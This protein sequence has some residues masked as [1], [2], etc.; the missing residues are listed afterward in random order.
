MRQRANNHN[1]PGFIYALAEKGEWGKYKIGHTVDPHR[2]L[3]GLQTGN[4]RELVLM[5]TWRT[6]NM[7]RDEKR[8]HRTLEAY[9][10]RGEWFECK[11]AVVDAAWKWATN[12][13]GPVPPGVGQVLSSI[14]DDY[15][16]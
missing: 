13:T 10:M 2:R 3:K 14:S 15:K 7:A 12:T 8:M 1:K 6:P 11:I 5:R 9:N 4:R 16:L